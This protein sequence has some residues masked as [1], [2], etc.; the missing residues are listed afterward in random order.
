MHIA[1][2]VVFRIIFGMLMLGAAIRF[3]LKGWVNDLYIQPQ[4]YF[5]YYGFEWIK[6]L[7]EFGMYALF[8][9]MIISYVCIILG[10]WYR[11]A[12]IVAFST[13]TYVELID[14]STYLNHYYFVSAVLFLLIFLPTNR[15]FSLDVLRKPSLKRLTVPCYT[16]DVLKLQL[17]IVYIYAG[18][19]KLNYDWLFRAM[20]LKIW[21]PANA[22]LPLIGSFLDEEW[23]AYFFSW[24]GAIY[25]LFI[26]FFLINKRTRMVAYLFVIAFHVMT[27]M[28]FP[29]GVFP[30]V[31]I[32][33]TLIFFSED[34]HKKTIELL[35]RIKLFRLNGFTVL[36]TSTEA[37]PVVNNKSNWLVTF[38]AIY[39][40][41]QILL[42]WRFLLYP[43]NLFW[44]EQ[45]YRFSWRVM[46]M[47]K[48]GTVFF[49]VKDCETG[50]ESEVMNDEF[51]TK[52]QEKMMATQPDMIVQYAHYLKEQYEKKGFKNPQV[53][54]EAY[55]T[56]NGS[57]SRLFIDSTVDLAKQKESFAPKDF[58]LPF[59]EVK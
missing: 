20:P 6:P 49:Y 39:F 50:F 21:L 16:I 38:F 5:T 47:E 23:V 32:L 36:S 4:F 12:T 33:S 30:Y 59:N 44:T 40:V 31:M 57:G 17:A 43:G 9:L 34:F 11:I 19:A 24:F 3:I 45:G 42:P 14:K 28:L 48:A 29:I 18:I 46:L 7:G 8:A 2:L 10:Y 53:R 55:V 35:M 13:F 58:I 25:D 1:P 15:F 41:I 22:H 26:V 51:L 37:S 54:A 27:K 56:L 52:N